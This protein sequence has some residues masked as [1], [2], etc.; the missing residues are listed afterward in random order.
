M[1]IGKENNQQKR[2]KLA[3]N[4]TTLLWWVGRKKPVMENIPENCV[5]NFSVCVK[6]L[7]AVRLSDWDEGSGS[8]QSSE[9]DREQEQEEEG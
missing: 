2:R 9:H 8:R 7:P 1:N 5:Q 3:E 4:F 6:S